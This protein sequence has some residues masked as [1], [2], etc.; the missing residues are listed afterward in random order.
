[1]GKELG[2]KVERLKEMQKDG[3]QVVTDIYGQYRMDYE[4]NQ[5]CTCAL[6]FSCVGL[7]ANQEEAQ[8]GEKISEVTSRTHLGNEKGAA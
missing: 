4:A 8:E 7:T 5:K 6:I 2:Q 3:F 1:M